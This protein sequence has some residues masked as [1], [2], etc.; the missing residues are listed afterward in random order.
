MQTGNENRFW[1]I[2]L[3]WLVDTFRWNDN[4]NETPKYQNLKDSLAKAHR[5]WNH[6]KLYFNCVNDPDL[7]DHAIFYMGAMEKKY[8]YLL[9]RARET[10]L[11]TDVISSEENRL[12]V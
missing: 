10:G 1:R 2:L 5:E 4:E 6:A 3:K 12:K 9:K 11:S 7:I 8:V